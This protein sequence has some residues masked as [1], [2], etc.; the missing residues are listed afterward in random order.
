MI[1]KYLIIAILATFC[2]TATLF[3]T[4]LPATQSQVENKLQV[5]A[6]DTRKST[7][8]Y[9]ADA[10]WVEP[11]QS[12]Y[13]AGSKFN[14]TLWLNM[15]ENIYG[16]QICLLYNRTQLMCTRAGFTNGITSDYF[17]GHVTVSV[18][19][20]IDT[21][22]FGNGT[23]MTYEGCLGQ[24]FISGPK[25]ASLMWAEFQVLIAT[26]GN[27]SS[28]FDISTLYPD[29]TW[30]QDTDLNKIAI[31]PHDGYY[32]FTSEPPSE[33]QIVSV[34]WHPTCPYPYVPS[35]VPRL[36][37]PVMILANISNV[38]T[39]GGS[40]VGLYYRVDG[41]EWWNT[42]MTYNATSSLWFVT[43]PGQNGN[44]TIAFFITARNSFG[45]EATSTTLSYSVNAQ[46]IGDING[47]GKVDGRD[48]VIPAKH[49]GEYTPPP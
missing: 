18:Q 17:N 22:T 44:T 46:L 40:F 41:G 19:P 3:L 45:E 25:S 29:W 30:V 31:T 49:F 2:L 9:D 15:T 13:G 42:T 32:L 12:I 7:I 4:K 38:D 10:M 37:E 11:N 35:T 43:I 47:D 34:E 6:S 14:I 1:R 27:F 21:G 36:Q 23:I 5:Q 8:L 48:I 20:V 28:K 16:W 24:D 39:A 26:G 33:P